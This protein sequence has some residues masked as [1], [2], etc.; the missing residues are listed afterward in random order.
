[1][2]AQPEPTE[3]T[4]T[5]RSERRVFYEFPYTGQDHAP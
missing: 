4:R 2:E 1:M 5:V 3:H